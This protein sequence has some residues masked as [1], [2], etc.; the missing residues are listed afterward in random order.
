MKIIKIIF[1]IIIIVFSFSSCK[2]IKSSDKDNE[3][4][5]NNSVSTEQTSSNYQ[6]IDENKIAFSSFSVEIPDNLTLLPDTKHLIAK[7]SDGTFQLMIEDKTKTVS[8]YK[9]YINDTYSQYSAIGLE[10][11]EIEDLSLNDS[12]ASRFAFHTK[13]EQNENIVAVF[14]FIE[15][16]NLKIDAFILLK[17]QKIVDYSDIDNYIASINFIEK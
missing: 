2:I 17:G 15:Q 14:Y 11:T 16:D 4:N 12:I 9:K 7:N 1:I 13:D 5:T 3:K 10:L 6:I 8:N